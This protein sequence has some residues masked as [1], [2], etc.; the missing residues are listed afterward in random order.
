MSPDKIP[1]ASRLKYWKK[2]EA[3]IFEFE[4]SQAK[5]TGTTQP[6]NATEARYLRAQRTARIEGA[7]FKPG[8]FNPSRVKKAMRNIKLPPIGADSRLVR[9]RT[10]DEVLERRKKAQEAL[11][12]EQE[13]LEALEAEHVAMARREEARREETRREEARRTNKRFKIP[14]I[15][16]ARGMTDRE[17]EEVWKEAEERVSKAKERQKVTKARDYT[18]K[19]AH[20]SEK[21]TRLSAK[22]NNASEKSS[23]HRDRA[24]KPLDKF[25]KSQGQAVS[26][27][28]QTSVAR[29]SPMMPIAAKTPPGE[30]R[31][32][33]QQARQK[34]KPKHTADNVRAKPMVDITLTED[35]DFELGNIME[36]VHAFEL[37]LTDADLVIAGEV[38]IEFRELPVISVQDAAALAPTTNF[39][40][41]NSFGGVAN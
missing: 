22:S 34:Q 31:K 15:S 40:M 20:H 1:R 33:Q 39:V 25:T 7:E 11:R 41:D 26:I 23:Q 30:R 21:P 18:K 8:N 32:L 37:E 38:E 28:K 29:K 24:D 36:Q 3:R 35:S 14:R 27:A 16:T 19:A 13:E 12:L 5:I 10:P 6:R 4:C 9:E 17:I 2:R